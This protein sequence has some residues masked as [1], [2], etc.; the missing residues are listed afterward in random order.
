MVSYSC[1]LDTDTALLIG[2]HHR[3]RTAPVAW[4]R[5]LARD[6][7]LEHYFTTKISHVKSGR[8]SP[9]RGPT[10]DIFSDQTA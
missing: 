10:V 8:P 4:E 2:D 7:S 5:V 3:P 6:R 1:A 9:G